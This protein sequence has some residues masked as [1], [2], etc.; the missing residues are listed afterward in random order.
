MTLSKEKLIEKLSETAYVLSADNNKA[1]VDIV[2]WNKIYTWWWNKSLSVGERL[3]FDIDTVLDQIN[4]WNRNLIADKIEI[5]L[6]VLIRKKE[7]SLNKKLSIIGEREFK[8]PEPTKE[9][10][11]LWGTY[12]FSEFEEEWTLL[13]KTDD[14]AFLGY[15]RKYDWDV[16]NEI[17]SSIHAIPRAI[18]KKTFIEKEIVVYTLEQ[19]IE[20]EFWVK[21]KDVLFINND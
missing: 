10:L 18:V 6:D 20:E 21:L 9:W 15:G 11:E 2:D 5:D 19:L 17:H 4:N 13:W 8:N 3:M 12:K 14:F 1:I 7:L 16:A